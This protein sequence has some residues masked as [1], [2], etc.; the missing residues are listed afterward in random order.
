MASYVFLVVLA[1]V[2]T[3][4]IGGAAVVNAS[5]NSWF[6]VGAL[7]LMGAAVGVVMSPA[8]AVL[9][10]RIQGV[11]ARPRQLACAVLPWALLTFVF[12]TVLSGY[13]MLSTGF[14]WRGNEQP[15]F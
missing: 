7:F 2:S 6:E 5:R 1:R 13:V 15:H 3:Y 9:V 14:E 8:S 10:S 4:S 12:A 11:T